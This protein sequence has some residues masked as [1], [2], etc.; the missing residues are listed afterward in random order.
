M[1]QSKVRLWVGKASSTLEAGRNALCNANKWEPGP[2]L[3]RA[4]L[5]ACNVDCSVVFVPVCFATSRVA[6]SVDKAH[7]TLSFVTQNGNVKRRLLGYHA[8]EK[9]GRL[10]ASKLH[11][12]AHV[13]KTALFKHVPQGG[14]LSTMGATIW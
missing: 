13:R 8:N 9:Q 14:A 7:N 3:L 6:S 10:S 11:E 2:M 1:R 5:V 4:L 12:A